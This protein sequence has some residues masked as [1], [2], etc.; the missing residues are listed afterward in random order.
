ML[1][2]VLP[3]LTV[4]EGTGI[5]VT[6]RHAL[7][8]FSCGLR[9]QACFLPCRPAAGCQVL[10]ACL[11]PAH[12]TACDLTALSPSSIFTSKQSGMDDAHQLAISLP[13]ESVSLII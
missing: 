6:T 2:A 1:P 8:S 12:G 13:F 5:T 9:L 11:S 4:K 7:E 3:H 10:P